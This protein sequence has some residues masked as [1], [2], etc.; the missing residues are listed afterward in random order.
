MAEDFLNQIYREKMALLKTKDAYYRNL[1]KNMAP[2]D[3]KNYGVFKKAV[4]KKGRI[5]LI[6]EVKKASPSVGLIREDFDALKIA[7]IYADNHAAAI[8]VLTEEHYFLGKVAYLRK[9]SD[10]FNVPTL[11]KDFIIHEYQIFEGAFCGASAVLLIVAMLEDNQMRDLMAAADSLGLDCLVEA[12]DEKD[13]ERAVKANAQIIG[14]NNRNLHTLAVDIKNCL[15]MIPYIPATTI[16]VAESGLKTHE[17][18]Q[19]VHAAGANA[20]LIG[21]TFMRAGDIGAKIKDVMY[22]SS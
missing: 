3:I 22:G 17:D 2:K 18:V 14:V 15:R 19:R 5:N 4:S 12:H 20:V 21:E 13:V 9:I 16:I 7:K 11:M 8:S 1:R 6:A 10:E